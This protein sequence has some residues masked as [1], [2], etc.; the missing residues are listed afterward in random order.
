MARKARPPDLIMTIDFGGSLT[1]AIFA[2]ELLNEN[3]LLME[4]E[5]IS[6]PKSAIAAHEQMKLGSPDP[7]DA[8][9]LERRRPLPA[10]WSWS[11]RSVTCARTAI[12]SSRTS[13]P[14]R[15]ASRKTWSSAGFPSYSA[16]GPGNCMRAATSRR[17]C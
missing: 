9:W 3:L 6:V 14:G 8:A 10:R 1:K 17:K 15:S 2:D 4:P 16:G 7:A 11:K 5:V 13:T 12:P